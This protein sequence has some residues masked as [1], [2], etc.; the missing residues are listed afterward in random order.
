MALIG[1]NPV[2]PRQKA[3]ALERVAQAVQIAQGVLGTALAVP[4]YLQKR[5]LA[6]QEHSI[7]QEELTN[8]RANTMADLQSKFRPVSAEEKNAGIAGQIYP[9]YESMGELV[10]M[11]TDEF[12]QKAGL[13]ELQNFYK[14]HDRVDA[15]TQG[16][17]KA[18]LG[19]GHVVWGIP[20]TD[21][22][23][24][25]IETESKLREEYTKKSA[26]YVDMLGAAHRIL[27]VENNPAGISSLIRNT[28]TLF[29]PS[30]TRAGNA[31]I[32]SLGRLGG[33]PA[34][35][36]NLFNMT[37]SKEGYKELPPTIFKQY[38]DLAN[39]TIHSGEKD[40]NIL[41]KSYEILSNNYKV[42]PRNV[43]LDYQEIEG[44]RAGNEL[45]SPIHAAHNKAE[46][47]K[48]DLLGNPL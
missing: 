34:E 37:F 1:V 12:S 10:P 36:Q 41:K 2:A 42:N 17:E 29:N 39:R 14:T 13:E 25:T 16:A 4:E 18:V 47:P 35:A 33:L 23:P 7:K 31:D 8:R 46:K 3:S 9:G 24:K 38:Q 28:T 6:K 21:L 26:D 5:D 11:K 20:K 45:P 15:N 48:T 32:E 30:L 22:D 43:L 27:Q 19:N 40:Q 44:L